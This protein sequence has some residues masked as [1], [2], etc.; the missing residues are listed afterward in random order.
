V[1]SGLK[2]TATTAPPWPRRGLGGIGKTQL[3]LEYAHRFTA[4]YDLIWWVPAERTEDISNS[5]ADLAHGMNLQVGDNA[6][7]AAV[8]ALEELR[9][10]SA[11]HW[12]LVFDN[13]DDPRQ[14]EPYLPA[15][16][17][18]VLITSRNQGWTHS[19]EPFEVD[20]FTKDESVAHLVR[21]VPDLATADA[22]RVADALGYLPLAVEQASAWLEQ[23]GMP[24]KA[25]LELLATQATRILA[26]NQPTDYPTPVAITWNLSFDRLRERSPAAMRLL[27]LCAFFGPGPISMGLLY[28]AQ[29]IEAL[30]PFDESLTE[31]LLLGRVIRDINGFAFA[32]VHQGSNSLQIRRLVQAVIRS[33]MSEEE[34][35]EARHEVHKIMTAAQSRKGE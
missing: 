19:A 27:Q 15:G 25:Y 16:S 31:M 8:A 28:G 13:A 18:H 7:E 21:H 3:A 2:A 26:V 11:L 1:P 6:A 35:E 14:L 9:R 17:G 30:L 10:N 33:Q 23:T 5:L 24:A 32:K 12:L 34:Q 29:M 4:D 22:S 20:V